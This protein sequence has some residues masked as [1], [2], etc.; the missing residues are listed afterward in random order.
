ML[1][2]ERRSFERMN[3]QGLV[4][5][6][7]LIPFHPVLGLQQVRAQDLSESGLQIQSEWLLPLKSTVLLEMQVPDHST[8]IQVIGS[9]IWISPS[10]ETKQW[11]LGIEFSDVGESARHGIRALLK[12]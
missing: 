9:V 4:Q 1:K 3:W 10:A 8:G 12:D 5:I 2:D 7:P 6:L 11:N